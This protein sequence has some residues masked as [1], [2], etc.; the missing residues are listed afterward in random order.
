MSSRSAR[1]TKRDFAPVQTNK[2]NHKDTPTKQNIKKENQKRL[3]SEDSARAHTGLLRFEKWEWGDP[4]TVSVSGLNTSCGPGLVHLKT[5]WEES[6]HHP[7]RIPALSEE[8]PLPFPR[9]SEISGM[10]GKGTQ[11]FLF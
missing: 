7:Q 9:R 3:G 8:K 11:L 6:H 10:G 4:C 2:N 5:I 1:T